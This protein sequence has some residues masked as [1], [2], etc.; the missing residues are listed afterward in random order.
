MSRRWAMS[1]WSVP[2]KQ[3]TEYEIRLSAHGNELILSING[4]E[5]LRA[6]DEDF[7]YGM[8]GCGSRTMGRTAFGDFFVHASL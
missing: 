1:Q 8:Y 5:V 4:E 6:E 3:E 7:A 2:W